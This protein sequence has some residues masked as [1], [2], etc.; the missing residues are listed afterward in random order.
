MSPPVASIANRLLTGFMLFCSGSIACAAGDT[1]NLRDE[2]LKGLYNSFSTPFDQLLDGTAQEGLSLRFAFDL[3]MKAKAVAGNGLQTQGDKPSSPTLQVGLKYVPLTSWFVNVNF[4][5]YL[6]PTI[7][8]P[9]NPDFTYSFGYDDWHPYTL[10]LTYSNNGGNRLNPDKSK[11]QKITQFEEGGWSLGYKFPMPDML[12]DTLLF[13]EDDTV[14]CNTS[15]NY[16][17]TYTDLKS[18]KKLHNKKTLALG[19]KYTFANSWYFNF[20]LPVYINKKQQQP[21][22]PDYTY[23][24]GYFDWH[25]GAYS[26]QYN[27]YSG[28]RFPWHKRVPLTGRLKDGSITISWSTNIL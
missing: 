13:N 24:F 26:I 16:S 25:P 20:S 8:A 22:D 27:N 17:R 9:W 1:G 28:N 11:G 3:P 18:G 7:Q 23:G 6:I 4:I 14:G 5:K 2:M 21:W 12:R 19:C 10:S 15:F